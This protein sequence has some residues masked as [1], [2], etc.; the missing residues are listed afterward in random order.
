MAADKSRSL[1]A[2]RNPGRISVMER[3]KQPDAPEYK[4]TC[5]GRCND[6]GSFVSY[7]KDIDA[8][9]AGLAISRLEAMEAIPGLLDPTHAPA[10][11]GLSDIDEAT[12]TAN[13]LELCF[14]ADFM[15]YALYKQ[16]E[17]S[18]VLRV[19]EGKPIDFRPLRP[20]FET[21]LD[22]DWPEMA[23]D[24]IA[25]A[26]PLFEEAL[27]KGPQSKDVYIGNAGYVLR[28]MADLADRIGDPK[29]AARTLELS[30]LVAPNQKKLARLVF[31]YEKLEDHTQLKNRLQAY[32]QEF[33]LTDRMKL[34]EAKLQPRSVQK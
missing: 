22:M 8:E 15:R 1:L 3:V 27:P 21:M 7:D 19:S 4:Y 16:T 6:N 24:F 26:L 17:I 14:Y 33:G 28:M 12:A 23:R 29:S 20:A 5:V 25:L 11:A 13:V 18:S 32:S 34:I 30:F 2:V 10:L 31:A 9:T